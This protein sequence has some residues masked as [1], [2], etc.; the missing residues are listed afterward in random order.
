MIF[1]TAGNYKLVRKILKLLKEDIKGLKNVS[2]KNR[3][4]GNM[5]VDLYYV[6]KISDLVDLLLDNFD[7]D[8]QLKRLN[9]EIDGNKVIFKK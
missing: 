7:R 3:G 9:P 4:K 5:I 2:Q 8:S 1:P 6:G